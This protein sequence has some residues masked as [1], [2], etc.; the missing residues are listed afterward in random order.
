MNGLAMM[1][2]NLEFRFSRSLVENQGFSRKRGRFSWSLVEGL[3]ETFLKIV[4]ACFL[5]SYSSYNRFSSIVEG[6]IGVPSKM[7]KKGGYIGRSS[8]Y[9]L[10]LLERV[11]K[12]IKQARQA[13]SG[14]LQG[15]TG[16][17][18][19]IE[20]TGHKGEIE[21]KRLKLSTFKTP[22]NLST[23]LHFSL[24]FAQFLPFSSHS[25]RGEISPCQR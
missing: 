23:P 2:K 16:R 20:S 5:S 7:T 22:L 17:A 25:F 10:N 9:L 14:I 15:W 6:R 1:N 4:N 12:V 11:E 21:V 19:H 8:T 3:V 24:N 18:L 13:K